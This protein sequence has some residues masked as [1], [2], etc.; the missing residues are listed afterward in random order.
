MREMIKR[1][2]GGNSDWMAS[3]IGEAVVSHG[4]LLGGD[5][6]SVMDGMYCSSSRSASGQ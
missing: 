5:Y 1:P 4:F 3:Q 6:A 2:G